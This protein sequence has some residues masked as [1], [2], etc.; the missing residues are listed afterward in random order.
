M[1]GYEQDN[2]GQPEIAP[3]KFNKKSAFVRE[4]QQNKISRVWEN[5]NFEC[6]LKLQGVGEKKKHL[7]S[8][9]F[10]YVLSFQLILYVYFEILQSQKL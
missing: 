2:S 6:V 1:A 9:V 10:F 8:E 7:F 4:K 3:K 5:Q